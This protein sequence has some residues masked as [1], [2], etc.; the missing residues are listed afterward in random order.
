MTVNYYV[1]SKGLLTMTIRPQWRKGPRPATT[2]KP[3]K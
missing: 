2:R 3:V 1:N